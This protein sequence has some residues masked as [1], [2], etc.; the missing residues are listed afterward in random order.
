MPVKIAIHFSDF[1][2]VPPEVLEEYG[3]FNISLVNDLPLFIDPFLLFH[4]SKPEYQ[5]L[6]REIIRYLRFLREA[7]RPGISPGLLT[8]W[9]C[10]PEVKQTWLGY[11]G[12]GNQGRGLGLGFAHALRDNLHSV[13]TNFGNEEVTRGS[14]LEKL[15]LIKSG[16]GRDN[17]SDFTTNLIKPHLLQYTQD[18]AVQH[19]P[20]H[21]R[22]TVWVEKVRFNYDTQ[23]WE[24]KRYDL[25]HFRGEFVLLTPRDILTR[26]D[27][28]IN[29]TDLL[30]PHTFNQIALALPNAVLRAQINNYFARAMATKPTKEEQEAAIADFITQHPEFIDYFIRHKEDQGDQAV[31]ISQ[32]KVELTETQFV[33]QLRD[34]AALLHYFTAFYGVGDTTY[35]ETHQRVAFL[36]DVIEH[37]GGHRLFYIN[38]KPV[39]RENDLQIAFRLVWFGTPSDVSREV[40]DGRGPADFKISRGSGDKTLAEFKLASNTQLRRNLERQVP[41]YQNAS[42]APNAIK[43][44]VYFTRKELQKVQ[45]ILNEFGLVEH[46][47]IVLIDA[48]MDNKPSGSMA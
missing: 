17:V 20:L 3:A 47:D 38:G 45:K 25:P 15:C 37:K 22:Q 34:L 11:S 16:V 44:I 48:R 46:P 41:I 31:I 2:Q 35:E 9:F 10:F 14:H 33:T 4:S 13:F 43:V 8:S 39:R 24:R 32:G 23:S 12:V 28:W 29:R 6:H 7:A 27:T 26:D 1:F 5:A 21:L 18:F 30:D 42:D 40:N 19:V 36:K